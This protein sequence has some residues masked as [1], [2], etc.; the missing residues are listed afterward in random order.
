MTSYVDRVSTM[1]DNAAIKN[2]ERQTRL[3]HITALWIAMLLGGV[4]IVLGELTG[5]LV[6]LHQ[7]PLSTGLIMIGT[8][9]FLFALPVGLL[10]YFCRSLLRSIRELEKRVGTLEH[11]A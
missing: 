4:L 8:C 2:L 9:L 6:W 11:D 1:V 5:G 7:V 3:S 10:T